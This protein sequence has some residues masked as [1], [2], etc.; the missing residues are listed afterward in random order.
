MPQTS[1]FPFALP[2]P[3]LGS[4]IWERNGSRA[5]QRVLSHES[6]ALTPSLSGL[7]VPK[8]TQMLRLQ[9]PNHGDT[10]LPWPSCSAVA[11][12][13]PLQTGCWW[14]SPSMGWGRRQQKS[15]NPWAFTLTRACVL[16]QPPRPRQAGCCGSLV[17]LAFSLCSPSYSPNSHPKVF[18]HL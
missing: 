17:S 13:S 8:T 15:P 11:S 5:F 6:R 1:F 7:G 12:I 3:A 9:I 18:L 10:D 14:D 2:L 16:T 4:R